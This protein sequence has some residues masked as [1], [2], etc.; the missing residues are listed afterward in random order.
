MGCSCYLKADAKMIRIQ[1]GEDGSI[2]GPA[3]AK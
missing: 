3:E 1:V 2:Q